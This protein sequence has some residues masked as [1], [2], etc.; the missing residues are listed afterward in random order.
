MRKGLPL[1][2]IVAAFLSPVC[3]GQRPKL[4][5]PSHIS[6][7]DIAELTLIRQ[8]LEQLTTIERYLLGYFQR[9]YKLTTTDTVDWETGEIERQAGKK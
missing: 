3:I 8:Q 9:K 5:L 7:A 2:L 6:A 1:L 4:E